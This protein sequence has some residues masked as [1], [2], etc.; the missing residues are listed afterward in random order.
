MI[1]KPSLA[2]S[3][4]Q[5]SM[6]KPMGYALMAAVF[7]MLAPMFVLAGTTGAEFLDTYNLLFGW[8]TGYL[9]RALAFAASIM[10]A[11]IAVGKQQPLL[12]GIGIVFA[13]ILGVGPNIVNG[14]LTAV[15]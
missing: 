14:I 11:L 15:I 3:M 5:L 1:L 12:A 4:P 7:L 10:G 2:L 9:A 13:V 6:S 8:T